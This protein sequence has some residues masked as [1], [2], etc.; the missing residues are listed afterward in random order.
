MNNLITLPY[1][2]KRQ[3]KPYFCHIAGRQTHKQSKMVAAVIYRDLSWRLTT[4][5]FL[6]IRIC[7]KNEVL[8]DKAKDMLYIEQVNG[9]FALIVRPGRGELDL[10]DLKELQ[11]VWDWFLPIDRPGHRAFPLSVSCKE[12]GMADTKFYGFQKR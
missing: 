10:D 6:K 7:Q 5:Y 12:S 3:L 9:E 1:I 2:R 11:Q 4:F 8:A